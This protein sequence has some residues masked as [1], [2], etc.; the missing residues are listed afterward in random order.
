MI[1][2]LF[3]YIIF[4]E[5]ILKEGFSAVFHLRIELIGRFCLINEFMLHL[6]SI[7]D[8]YY[9]S[10]LDYITIRCIID[11]ASGK[12]GWHFKLLDLVK[13]LMDLAGF[14]HE[15]FKLWD[16]KDVDLLYALAYQRKRVMP[17]S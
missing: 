14:V 15:I 7:Y 13:A 8:V 1:L 17:L 4:A 9:L 6:E 12:L 16:V 2:F 11:G 3:L 5:L 10:L